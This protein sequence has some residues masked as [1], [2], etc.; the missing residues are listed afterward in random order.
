MTN[1]R[2]GL[3]EAEE[4]AMV[5]RAENWMRFELAWIDGRWRTRI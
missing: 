2:H 3:G 1:E 4:G 5:V